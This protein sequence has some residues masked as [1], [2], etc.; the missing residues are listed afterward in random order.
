MLSCLSN[1]NFES[2]AQTPRNIYESDT[3]QKSSID[4][5]QLPAA[6]AK[7]AE[8]GKMMNEFNLQVQIRTRTDTHYLHETKVP[9]L[10]KRRRSGSI[11]KTETTDARGI[12][13]KFEEQARPI[14]VRENAHAQV[15]VPHSRKVTVIEKEM[16]R[17]TAYSNV[18]RNVHTQ[19]S[20]LSKVC[21]QS[22]AIHE[23]HG[24]TR[25]R[26]LRK[27]AAAADCKAIHRQSPCIDKSEFSTLVFTSLSDAVEVWEGAGDEKARHDL[28]TFNI[29]TT[30]CKWNEPKKTKGVNYSHLIAHET[31][32]VSRFRH[33]CCGNV[34]FK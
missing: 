17:A 6:F 31:D 21:E 15:F 5:K 16:P 33:A 25:G 32:M 2:Q 23:V 27:E 1:S 24:V 19:E 34:T 9:C 8:T 3:P 29:L 10:G 28:P 11:D 26:I 13:V 18:S 4:N 30:V 12:G 14:E 22:S 7:V 20:Q